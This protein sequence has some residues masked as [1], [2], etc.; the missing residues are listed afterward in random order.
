MAGESI[1]GDLTFAR[2]ICDGG[3]D[4]EKD[5]IFLSLNKYI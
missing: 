5:D 2:L 3:T 1:K 4:N